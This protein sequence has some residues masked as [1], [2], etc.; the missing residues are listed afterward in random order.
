MI[1]NVEIRLLRV[2]AMLMAER[3]VSRAAERLRLSQPATSHALT[4]L[5]KLFNDPL[6]LRSRE[7]M[8]PTDRALRIEGDIGELLAGYD[9][10]VAAPE[11]FRPESSQRVFV[12]TATEYAEFVLLPPILARVRANAPHIRIEVRAPN[13]ARALDWL[14]SGEIDL[15]LAWVRDP[16]PSLRS[17]LLFHDRLVCVARAGHPEISGALT[18]AQYMELPHARPEIAGRTTSGRVIDEAVT[19]LG[20]KLRLALSVQNYLMVPF[21]VAAS[22]VIATLPKRLAMAFAAQLR[23]QILEPPLRLPRMRYAA[24]WHGRMHKDPAHQWLRRTVHDAAR[25]LRPFE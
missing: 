5:R 8:V 22:D 18:L 13:Q 11:P 23:L 21:T 7:G 9:R 19:A 20:G 3:S 12:L 1:D 10:L 6:L 14:E 15:R 17:Q 16:T 24:Y 4:R 2:F 25:Q